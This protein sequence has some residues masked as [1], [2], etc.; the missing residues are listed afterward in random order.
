MLV[1]RGEGVLVQGITGRQGR[2]WTEKMLE[3][4]TRVVA[5]V[6]PG[7]GGSEVCGVPVYD[8]VEEATK[9]HEVGVAVLFTPAGATKEAALE[10]L[11]A[12]VRKLVLLAEGVPG[13]DAMEILAEAR[14]VGAQVLG[15]NT[16]GVA[17][18]GEAMVGIIPAFIGEIFR[19]G[20]VGIVSR[21]GS[22]GTLAC[23]YVAQ[24]G[25]G[26]SAFIGVGGDP[27]VGTTMQEACA[28]L[29]KDERT[30]AVVLVGEIGGSQEE[31][32]AE[33]VSS[34]RKPVVAMVVGREAP[35]GKRMGHAGAIVLGKRGSAESKI[36][37]LRAAGARVAEFPW[38]V[39]RAVLEALRH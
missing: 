39:G 31:D 4:G 28:M 5:G 3:C 2:F 26:Q 37:A 8:S 1:T 10:S 23:L 33:Y 30:R 25:L 21:S 38:E 11:R 15:P 35:P 14:A 13:H 12:G 7:R 19:P 29:E 27:I 6:S 36:E 20:E 9:H 32:A 16:A 22:L 34:M 24:A 17:V 18:P